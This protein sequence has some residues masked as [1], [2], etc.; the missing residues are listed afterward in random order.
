MTTQV[1]TKDPAPD[2][3]GAPGAVTPVR[4]S[5][6]RGKATGWLK[7]GLSVFILFHLV[8]VILVPNSDNYAGSTLRRFIQPYVYL[9]EM[10]NAW[11][12][13]SPNPEPPIYVEY[14]LV[15]EKGDVVSRSSWPEKKDL[16]WLRERQTRRITA[17][18]F[19]MA[20]D[21]R[22][23]KMMAPY[24]CNLPSKPH[25]VRLYKMVYS[26]PSPEDIVSGKRTMGD[27]VGA[28]RKFVSH[29][30]CSDFVKADEATGLK[31]A[32]L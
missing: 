20:A 30:F 12:F 24:L 6:S 29:S 10:T 15:N 31:E 7:R 17:T 27:D 18:D 1:V 21:L 23:E 4:T 11:N 22:A 16:F 3:A 9:F 19:M 5:S 26:V 13:F 32:G 25:A 14:E 8:S 2:A 28:D